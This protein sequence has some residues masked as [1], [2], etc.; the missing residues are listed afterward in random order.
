METKREQ[1]QI[2]V[3]FEADMEADSG[4]RTNQGMV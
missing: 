1:I 4:V 3:H 2:K